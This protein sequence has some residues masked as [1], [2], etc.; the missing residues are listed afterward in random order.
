MKIKNIKY[1][2]LA[3][4]FGMGAT[5][6]DDFLDRPTEDNYNQSNFYQ[7]DT[8]C[9]QGV[10]FL[11]NSPWYDFQRGFFKVGEVMSG[12][13]YWGKSPYLDFTV[14]GTDQDL[15]NMSYSLW[16]VIAYCNTVYKTLQTANCSENV[17]RQCMAECLSWK[18]MAYFY[19]HVLSGLYLSYTIIPK[20]WQMELIMTK[21]RS[22]W[23]M[24]M[25]ILS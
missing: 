11:Y 1:V 2:A 22:C 18:A 21:R 25:N 20:N 8:Q 10:N 13:Y 14:N 15:V 24:S 12:N 16:S 6:C 4:V 23:L 7:N 19:L 17:R 9:V 5:S 3:A